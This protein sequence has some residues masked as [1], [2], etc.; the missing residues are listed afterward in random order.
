MTALDTGLLSI[1][2][3]IVRQFTRSF[4]YKYVEENELRNELYIRL[5]EELTNKPLLYNTLS[6]L[7]KRG[8]TIASGY[9]KQNRHQSNIIVSDRQSLF[10]LIKSRLDTLPQDKLTDK[11]AKLKLWC[12][13][14]DNRLFK[15][16][17][18][19]VVAYLH[20]VE[21]ISLRD[22][23]NYFGRTL[24]AVKNCIHAV[25]HKVGRNVSLKKDDVVILSIDNPFFDRML[26]KVK[27]PTDY[28]AIVLVESHSYPERKQWELRCTNDEMVYIGTLAGKEIPNKIATESMPGSHKKPAHAADMGKYTISMPSIRT[29]E[30]NQEF[31]ASGDLCSRCGGMCVRTGT[32]ITCQSCGDNSGC[33]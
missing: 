22:I 11:N 30:Q 9:V 23:A 14:R 1:V 19:R 17:D 33:G 7:F 13:C 20:L 18:S 8:M 6:D 28:G 16:I 12:E 4:K 5:K 24:I 2:D 21:E 3:R 10:S 29:T 15:G 25:S 26:G 31:K 32:C 27:E